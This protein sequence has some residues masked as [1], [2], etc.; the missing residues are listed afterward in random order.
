MRSGDIATDLVPAGRPAGALAS[1]RTSAARATTCS[2]AA[3]RR[4]WSERSLFELTV[5][6]RHAALARLRAQRLHRDRRQLRRPLPLQPDLLLAARLPRV[7][8]C[9]CSRSTHLFSGLIVPLAFFPEP[10]RRHP[11]RAAVRGD[12]PDADRH[13]RRRAARRQHRSARS[14]PGGLGGRARP[15]RP[16]GASLRGRG[17]WW[18]R[19]AELGRGI[20]RRLIGAHVRCQLQYRTSLALQLVGVVRCYV[21]RLR[22]RSSSSSRTCPTLGGWTRGGGRVAL[23]DRGDLLRA[24]RPGRRPPR[25]LPADDPRRHLRPR[26]RPAAAARCCRWSPPT[27]R[28]AGSARSLQAVVVLDRRLGGG[29]RRLDGRPGA[30]GSAR[31]RLR[32][33]DLRRRLDRA[34]DDRVLDRRRD[35]VRRTPSPTAGASSPQYPISI[36]GRWLR[37]LRRC[38]PIPMAFVSYFPA[39][40]V[41]DRPDEL[42]LPDALRYRLAARRARDRDRRRRSSGANAVR[43]Y[44]S[45]GGEPVIEVDGRREALR[46]ARQARAAAAR[47]P[48]GRRPSTASPSTVERG[49]DRRLRRPE[50]RRQVDDDQDADRHPR[51][52]RRAGS[53]VAGLDPSRQRVELARR[54]GVV[55]GQRVAAL[56]GPA[57]ARLVRAAAP[58]LPRAG[59]ALPR[60][61]S[62]RFGELLDARRRSSRR[63]C[64]S[65]RSASGCAAI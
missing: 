50:R 3:Y 25:P 60:R 16:A 45:A 26:P 44:R 9:S 18:C 24:L 34:R 27:S 46:R 23:R 38:S 7:R 13:L 19:V 49:R 31:H 40:Y 36:F 63:R 54:I 48:G 56:V 65:S 6:D 17:S 4:S 14:P 30:D 35:R 10:A 37:R 1:P 11:A 47:A 22:R 20:Y 53:A 15:R 52:E 58:H 12:A 55:F 29:R 2:C 61:T 64:A 5:P 28:C 57:A 42:G 62:T 59:G 21:P 8:C 39:L 33:G 41:L 43:H 51:A 32:R